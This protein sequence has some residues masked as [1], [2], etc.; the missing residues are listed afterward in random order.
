MRPNPSSGPVRA[1][2]G[3]PA[4]LEPVGVRVEVLHLVQADPDHAQQLHRVLGLAHQGADAALQALPLGRQRGGVREHLVGGVEVRPVG[5]VDDGLGP[6][7]DRHQDPVGARAGAEPEADQLLE[8]AGVPGERDRLGV[9]VE[10]DEPV[11]DLGRLDRV[12]V[13]ALGREGVAR[14]VEVGPGVE[15][16]G[17][18]GDRE[19]ERGG[20]DRRGAAKREAAAAM[21]GAGQ[22]AEPKPRPRRRSRGEIARTRRGGVLGLGER[23]RGQRPEARPIHGEGD[24]GIR[25][26]EYR[27]CRPAR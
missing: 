1:L 27:F 6:L 14:D 8:G 10:V 12:V 11:A 9:L 26:R 24:G 23:R 15:R 16:S 5:R 4:G 2:A 22:G 7:V 13:E 18:G 3:G 17:R 21:R 25:T 20:G 19:A